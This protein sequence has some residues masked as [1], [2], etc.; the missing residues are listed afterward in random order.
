MSMSHINQVISLMNLQVVFF[1]P[2]SAFSD[3]ILSLK[4]L[5]KQYRILYQPLPEGL[6]ALNFL[7]PSN[8]KLP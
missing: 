7:P 8:Q 3:S 1:V 4:H 5:C 6:Y 2:S